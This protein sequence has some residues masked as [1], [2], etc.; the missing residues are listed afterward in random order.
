LPSTIELLNRE[1]K[2]QGLTVL[3]INLAEPRD[4]LAAWVMR[5]NVTSTVL[6]DSRGDVARSYAIAH[7]PTVF[8]VDRRGRLV[9]KAIGTR[10][11]TG[12]KGL[13][14]LRFVMER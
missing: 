8:L 10:Q 3:A 12:D 6:L 1:L 11:W 7:T 2:D 5:R 14:L 4:V 13:A 9:G